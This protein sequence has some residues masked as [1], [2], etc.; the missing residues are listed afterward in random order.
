MFR[1]YESLRKLLRGRHLTITIIAMEVMI[2]RYS[3]VGD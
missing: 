1:A 2:Y 3:I